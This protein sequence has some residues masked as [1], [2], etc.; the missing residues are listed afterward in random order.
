[1]KSA[2]FLS[3]FKSELLKNFALNEFVNFLVQG[4]TSSPDQFDQFQTD[5]DKYEQVYTNE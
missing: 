5:L 3:E 2:D 4:L 1:M